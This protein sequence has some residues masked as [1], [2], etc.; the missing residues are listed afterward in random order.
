MDIYLKDADGK[1]YHSVHGTHVTQAQIQDQI[2]DG[3]IVIQD[4]PIIDNSA[5]LA[6]IAK[7][8]KLEEIQVLEQKALR[9]IIAL[10][11][12]PSD[13]TEKAYLQ[14][15]RDQIEALAADIRKG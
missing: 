5:Q 10:A 15:Y 11:L 7:Y 3:R 1:L 12:N 13:N 4:A 8:K 2:D 14:K 9:S 6:E